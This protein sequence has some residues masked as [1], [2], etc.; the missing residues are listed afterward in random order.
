MSLCVSSSGRAIAGSYSIVH[1]CYKG[2]K[3]ATTTRG[4]YAWMIDA[5]NKECDKC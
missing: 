4:V 1:I 5:A 2:R 3:D